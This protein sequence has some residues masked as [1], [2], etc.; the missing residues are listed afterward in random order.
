MVK[1]TM[2]TERK[3]LEELPMKLRDITDAL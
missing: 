2:K 1:Q 3:D